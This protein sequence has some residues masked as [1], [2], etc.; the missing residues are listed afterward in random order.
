LLTNLNE[1]SD[2]LNVQSFPI[3]VVWEAKSLSQDF[4]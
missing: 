3:N 1:H 2:A 4:P